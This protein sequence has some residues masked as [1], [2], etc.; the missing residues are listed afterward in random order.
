M[1][2]ERS[3]PTRCFGDDTPGQRNLRFG[4]HW[5]MASF[6]VTPGTWQ[7]ALIRREATGVRSP[8]RVSEARQTALTLGINLR[9][10]R[11]CCPVHK[12]GPSNCD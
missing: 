12:D 4:G 2:V 3:G 1:T 10:W 8:A 5:R 11:D 9:P 7:D 6:S